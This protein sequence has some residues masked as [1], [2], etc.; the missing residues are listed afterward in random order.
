MKRVTLLTDF[1]TADGYVAAIKG[2][3]AG[4]APDV[5]V[6]DMTHDIPFGDIEGAAWTLSRYWRL[7]PEGSVH[8]AVVDPG[9]GTARRPL[10]AR[11][12]GRL[13]VAPDNGVLT[14]VLRGADNAALVQIDEGRYTAAEV[15]RT[16]HGRDIFAPVAAHL[17]N[18]VRLEDIGSATTA[19]FRLE[20]PEPG[21]DTAGVHGR[22]AHVDRFGNLITDI[23]AD[24]VQPGNWVGIGDRLV[25]PLRTTYGDVDPGELVALIGS[26]GTLEVAVRDGSAARMLDA[27]RGAPVRCR[28]RE[29]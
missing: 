23:P 29:E 26:A 11:V 21:R 7:Y 24:W 22:V 6:D 25:G 5:Q 18:G 19:P 16:F 13:F 2:M 15:S 10:A 9:V 20:L 4:I 12:D 8:L 1:G 27:G 14:R 3:I 28:P 17:A